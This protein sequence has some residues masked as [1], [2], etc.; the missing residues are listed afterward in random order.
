MIK[1]DIDDI[2]NNIIAFKI[3]GINIGLANSIRRILIAEI[4]TMCI[5]FVNILEDSHGLS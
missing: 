3:S 2:D 1:I 5:N 4:P